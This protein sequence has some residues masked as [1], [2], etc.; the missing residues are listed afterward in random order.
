MFGAIGVCHLAPYVHK[1]INEYYKQELEFIIVG[2]Q[3]GAALSFLMR[4]L[5]Y[6]MLQIL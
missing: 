5:I 1:K 6:S 4:F 2:P 3:S